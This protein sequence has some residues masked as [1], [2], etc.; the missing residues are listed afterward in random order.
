MR[1]PSLLWTYD[2]P[3][4]ANVTPASLPPHPAVDATLTIRGLN[5]GTSPGVV[6]VS[7]AP[8]RCDTWTNTLVVCGAPSGVAATSSLVVFAAS[9]QPS[10]AVTVHYDGPVV[11]T[12]T[13]DVLS[14]TAGGGELVVFGSAFAS[15]L[16]VTVWLYRGSAQPLAPWNATIVRHQ[17]L[18]QAAVVVANATR[19]LCVVP[20]GSGLNWRVVVVNH[21][22]DYDRGAGSRSSV[23]SASLWQ[24]SQP[25]AARVSYRAPV[26]ASVSVLPEAVLSLP[27]DVIA[28]NDSSTSS[29]SALSS[30]GVPK[31]AR[32]AFIVL[33][34]GS[35]FSHAQPP[36]VTIGTATCT[37]LP[38]WFGDS[39]VL[40]R[41]PP[42][43]VGVAVT[44]VLVQDG[45]TS[46]SEPF[47]YDDPVTTAVSPLS[48]DAV[49]LPG[50]P[51]SVLTLSGVNFGTPDGS[52]EPSGYHFGFIGTTPCASLS[53]LSDDTVLCTLTGVFVVGPY[54]V[55]VALVDAVPD[56]SDGAAV[57]A[58]LQTLAPR[59]NST[60]AGDAVAVAALCPSGTFG[61]DGALCATCP[62]GAICSGG[63]ADP[64]AAPGYFPTARAAFVP[65]TPPEAC[66]GGV[67]AA[68]VVVSGASVSGCAS[69][70]AGDRCSTCSSTAYR[71]KSECRACPNTAWLL[72]L[73]FGAAIMVIVSF[74]VY[75][76][77][78]KINLAGVSIGVVRARGVGV[79][80]W[81]WVWV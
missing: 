79:W 45:Q 63:V 44:V 80:V 25:A 77:K 75:L 78:K 61:A 38:Q 27:F 14:P 37:V 8:T 74:A 9:G 2:P 64:I 68:A 12:V 43:R 53:W 71:L 70:Y 48:F 40:C 3:V 30:A 72:F 51:R 7:G 34:R 62:V 42:R 28:G 13:G 22:F 20:P 6:T 11:T 46:N 66:V 36:T 31:P 54:S 26:I 39:A 18:L 10:G 32:G 76:S 21:D 57:A 52:G 81:V 50:T 69:N 41:A 65:C 4:I 15:P 5:F 58:F 16:P 47:A 60:V 23:L 17:A 55:R 29:S 67:T 1:L 56:G 59:G 73:L 35:D 49:E 19:L 33:V 24:A